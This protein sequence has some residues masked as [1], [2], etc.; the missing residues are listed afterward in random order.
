VQVGSGG[1]D[2]LSW[3]IMR[4]DAYNSIVFEQNNKMKVENP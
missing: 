1:S 4:D 2:F 3:G